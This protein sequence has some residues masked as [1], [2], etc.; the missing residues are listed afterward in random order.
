MDQISP[1]QLSALALTTVVQQ[2]VDPAAPVGAGAATA[3]Q[4]LTTDVAEVSAEGRRRYE[5][6]LPRR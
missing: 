2:R 5:E 3:T 1:T 6:T 4:R